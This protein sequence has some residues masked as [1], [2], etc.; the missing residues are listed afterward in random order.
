[1]MEMTQ[2]KR[3]TISA[4]DSCNNNCMFCYQRDNDEFD[5]LMSSKKIKAILRKNKSKYEEVSFSN[6]EPTLKKDLPGLISYAKKLGYKKIILQTNGRRFYY[7]SFCKTIIGAGCTNFVVAIH[8]HNSKIHDTLTSSR[9]SFNQTLRGII[10]LRR[11]GQNVATITTI[12][13]MNY[14]HLKDIYLLLRK[15]GIESQNYIFIDPTGNGL[16]NFYRVVPRISLAA[17]YIHQMLDFNDTI[18]KKNVIKIS[19]KGI[20]YCL[21]EGYEHYISEFYDETMAF[22]NEEIKDIFKFRSTLGKVKFD[23]CGNCKYYNKCEGIW[24]EYPKRFGEDE[25]H[26]VSKDYLRNK[27]RKND[28]TGSYTFKLVSKKNLFYPVTLR[29][30]KILNKFVIVSDY[31][32]FMVCNK[33]ELKR[34]FKSDINEK[35]ELLQKLEGN[36]LIKTRQNSQKVNDFTYRDN[37]PRSGVLIHNIVPT[38]KCNLGCIYC[39]ATPERKA[40]VKTDLNKETAKNICDFIFNDASKDVD[41]ITVEFQGGEPLINFDTIRYIVGY[42]NLLK[43]KHNKKVNYIIG[44][45]TTLMDRDKLRFIVDNDMQVSTSIDG[46]PDIH[47]SNRPYFNGKASLKDMMKQLDLINKAYK[48]NGNRRVYSSLTFTKDNLKKFREVVDFYME[49]N[50]DPI[51]TRFLDRLGHA[52]KLWDTKGYA[53]EEYILFFR[54]YLDYL[55]EL[56]RKGNYIRDRSTISLLIMMFTR[57]KNCCFNGECWANM[58]TLSYCPNGDIYPCE[59][60]RH[61]KDKNFRL[62]NVSKTSYLDL[63]NSEKNKNILANSTTSNK[64][65]NQCVWK[66]YCS[67]CVAK[68]YY[69]GGSLD[70]PV[71]GTSTCKIFMGQYDFIFEKII[72]DPKNLEILKS[73]IPKE[74]INGENLNFL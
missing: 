51:Q 18:S 40:G 16:K 50:L 71:E 74:L 63:L 8:G 23:K 3:L 11:M 28:I 36:L 43:Q 32:S 62:G 25:F 44:T 7:A 4:G 24:K 13:K 46:P 35:S 64:T 20:P 42:I 19:I 41:E 15:I 9:G 66:P 54:K 5:F 73:W 56:N 52:K 31:G 38:D 34:L 27:I 39:Q 2:N 59:P 60:L 17:P 26:I 67:V 22:K 70:A 29:A 47:D 68:R 53:P 37:I 49:N 12:T 55:L 21:M 33:N 10:N 48:R 57:V 61:L 65:C 45:N 58:L 14:Q 72:E 30:K 1:M 69:E 6:N